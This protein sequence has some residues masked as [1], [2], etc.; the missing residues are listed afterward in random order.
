[1]ILCRDKTDIG[2]GGVGVGGGKSPPQKD[3]GWRE[4]RVGRVKNIYVT[5]RDGAYVSAGSL[6]EVVTPPPHN[7]DILHRPVATNTHT[8]THYKLWYLFLY[9]EIFHSKS[10]ILLGLCLVFAVFLTPFHQ[11]FKNEIFN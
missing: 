1:M 11:W 10:V 9:F 2:G 8:H 3:I 4:E 7:L 5:I 6:S